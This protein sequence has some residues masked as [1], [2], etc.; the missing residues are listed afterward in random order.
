MGAHRQH[1]FELE[2]VE[3]RTYTHVRVTIYP[4][5]GIKRIRVIGKAETPTILDSRPNAVESGAQSPDTSEIITIP[6]VP[7]TAA[8]YRP[9]GQVVQAYNSSSRPDGVKVTPANAG[10]ADK[11]H[12]LSLLSSSYP[13]NAGATTGIS[14]YR[15]KPLEDIK[16]GVTVLRTLERHPYTSQAF[17][18]MG[19][20]SG[21]GLS[22]PGNSYLVVVALNG[23]DDRPDMTTLKA[24][25]ASSAQGIS[26]DAGIWRELSM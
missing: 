5:G 20:G 11:F 18:P 2:N 21:N 15:C 23:T 24:F 9:F 13:S 7:L 12:K 3:N 17:I 1:Y 8:A 19:S 25:L 22:E 14:V 26:Y 4:D 16:D 6:V 10:T